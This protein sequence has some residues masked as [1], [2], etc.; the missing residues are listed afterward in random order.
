MDT[1][2]LIELVRLHG[3][4]IYGFCYKLTGNKEDTDDLYQETF[5][6]AVK[7]RPKMDA[8]RNPKAFLI[9]IAIRLHD[10][11]AFGRSAVSGC[12]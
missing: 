5:L 9:S 3:K 10:R 11:R 12:V 4:S 8:S 6:K 1:D 7:L 2:E